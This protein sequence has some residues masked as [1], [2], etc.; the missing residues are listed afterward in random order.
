MVQANAKIARFM[1]AVVVGISL[2]ALAAPAMSAEPPAVAP[3]AFAEPVTPGDL[4]SYQRGTLPI[5]LSAPHGGGVRVPGS[6][7]RTAGVAG[8]VTVRDSNTDRLAWLVAQRLT[9]RLGAKPFVV[10]A[11]FSRKD[12]DANRAAGNAFEN[13]AAK[14]HYDA[15]HRALR[16]AV[17]EVRAAFPAGILI[18]LHGQ[19]RFP[20]AVVR[21][22]RNGATVK[23]LLT[24]HGPEAVVGPKSLMGLLARKG[25]TVMPTPDDGMVPR[26][27]PD[28]PQDAAAGD[29]GRA[30]FNPALGFERYFN[31]GFIVAN[32]GSQHDDGLD[33]IQ[34]E[35]GEQRKPE[36]IWVFARELA[37]AIADFA[38]EYV[39]DEEAKKP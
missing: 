1:P 17:D 37:D 6:L 11:Q 22:T 15:Y 8:V 14:R 36:Q 4:V 34:L 39:L 23:R 29:A 9:E 26:A 3:S 20:E 13:D 5:I 32:Y 30:D 31:G 7:E 28:E 27:V 18:D 38:K 25:H 21:G 2:A 33:A 24:R 12:A 16:S 35:I 10:V 19:A